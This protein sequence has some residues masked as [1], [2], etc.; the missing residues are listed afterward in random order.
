MLKTSLSTSIREGIRRRIEVG[1]WGDQ[2]P[3]EPELA[4]VF[5]ASRETVR[6]A[7]AVLEAEGLLY[8]V[9]GK[10]TFVETRVSFNPLSGALSITEEL[11]RCHLS[12]ENEVLEFGWIRPSE[13]P[14]PFLRSALEGATKIFRLKRLRTSKEHPLAV[15]L[16]YFRD[17]DFPGLETA[18]FSQSLHQ[19]MTARYGLS[20]D[21][22]TNRLMALD[23]HSSADRD[24][25]KLLGSRQVLR[26]ERILSRR[27]H[28]YYATRF[29]LRTDLYPLEYTQLPGHPHGRGL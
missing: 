4:K 1:E 24:V 7:L 22:V 15:E 17:S 27:R 13:L 28:A 8:R 18:E 11:G 10:G 2:L 21:R 23:F 16:S 9:H 20:P 19:L 3:A 29:V 26:V 5:G 12:V 14:S 6:K 25:A